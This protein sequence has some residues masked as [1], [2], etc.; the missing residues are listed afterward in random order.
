MSMKQRRQALGWS[1]H[2]LADRAGLDPRVVQ[3]CELGQWEDPEAQGRLD[4]VLKSAEGG[5]LDIRIAPLRAPEGAT[6][7]GGEVPLGSREPA[8][9]A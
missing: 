3:L 8:G 1:R 2:E 4:Y 7:Q 6:I 9:E 5:D